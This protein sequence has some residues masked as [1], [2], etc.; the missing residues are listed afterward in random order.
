M[1]R[2]KKGE[3]ES[4]RGL[5]SRGVTSRLITADCQLLPPRGKVYP[6]KGGECLKGSASSISTVEEICTRI[7]SMAGNSAVS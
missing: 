2:Q 5:Q 4:T 3:E 6:R 1:W 7:V